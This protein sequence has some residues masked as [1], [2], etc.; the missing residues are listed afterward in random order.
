MSN[1]VKL[2]DGSYAEL[3]SYE[4][5]ISTTLATL[6]PKSGQTYCTVTLGAFSYTYDNNVSRSCGFKT[7]QS[8][9]SE[10]HWD[11]PV[12][13]NAILLHTK[14]YDKDNYIYAAWC[15]IGDS[16]VSVVSGNTY[17]TTNVWFTLGFDAKDNCTGIRIAQYHKTGA[18]IPYINEVS[19]Q[20]IVPP[21]PPSEEGKAAIVSIIA[22]SE[23]TPG[24]TVNITTKILN[25][26]YTDSL[27]TRLKN[28]DTG[29]S[30]ADK[31]VTVL[32]NK[33][34][35]W[36]TSIKITQTTDFHGLIEAGHVT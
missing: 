16:W 3:G 24:D 15:L 36:I 10:W 2:E 23:F 13:I 31:T 1:F 20:Y 8:C 34:Y 29:T 21:P 27:F 4:L 12:K 35:D 30:L 5:P 25:Q 19:I 18:A 7:G 28:K 17:M 14:N 9:L 26:G 22:P 11:N 33:T 32:E 6:I